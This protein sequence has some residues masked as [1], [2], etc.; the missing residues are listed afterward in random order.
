[1]PGRWANACL[2]VSRHWLAV[3]G[4]EP[5]RRWALRAVRST[6][7][8]RP[9]P[10]AVDALTLLAVSAQALGDHAEAEVFAGRA[11]RLLATGCGRPHQLVTAL[12]HLGD[13]RRLRGRYRAAEEALSQAATVAAAGTDPSL[14][15]RVYTSLGV[16]CKDSGRY[17]EA[18]R[19]YR[20][21]LDRTG[22]RGPLSATLW[23]NLAGLDHARG[24]YHTAEQ[25]ARRAIDLRRHAVGADHPELA[26][27]ITVLAAS[28]AG[29]G[30]LDEAEARY[31]SALAIVRRH[32]GDDHHEVA[33]VLTGL[34]G[35]EQQRHRPL[36]AARL[37]RAALS[38][39]RR[40]L[41]AGHP[42]VAV[43]MNNL[44]VSLHR[45][46]HQ[47]EAARLYR[48]ALAILERALPPGHPTT[49]ACR[50]NQLLAQ[51]PVD[52]LT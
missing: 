12:V 51:A 49:V 23:H 25:A 35:L 38:I 14:L 13:I 11:L 33:V 8:A 48:D 29:Q 6:G 37:Q 34:G 45:S 27:D 43:A 41:G 22:G 39:K 4:Y 15:A 44:A 5:A 9:G 7:R 24:R 40:V 32:L 46:G 1:M 50:D 17:D 18:E 30:R 3:G 19:W 26:R 36:E 20:Q 16:I 42:D 47:D 31:R 28:L 10:A 2:R 52:P 21:A